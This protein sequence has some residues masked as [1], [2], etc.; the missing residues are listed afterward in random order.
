MT[1][2]TTQLIGKL[3]EGD[4]GRDAVHIALLP[5]TAVRLMVPGEH[6]MNGIVD[7]FLKQS[8]QPG[9]KFW[10]FLYPNTIT[11]LRHVWTHPA[12]D[13]EKSEVKPRSERDVWIDRSKQ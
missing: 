11:S 6:L 4:P 7:P 3:V 9:E 12:F 10:L 5:M 13:D 1:K 2:D 8:I